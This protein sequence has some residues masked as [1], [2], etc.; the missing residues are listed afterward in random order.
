MTEQERLTCVHETIQR[1]L[2]ELPFTFKNLSLELTR[3][4]ERS[5]M[6]IRF[7]FTDYGNENRS[8]THND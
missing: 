2:K 3:D 7:R 4:Y 1:V 8:L 6:V 5:E